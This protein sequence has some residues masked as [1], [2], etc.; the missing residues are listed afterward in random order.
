MG[1]PAAGASTATGIC[2]A[3]SSL[4]AAPGIVAGAACFSTGSDPGRA[5]VPASASPAPATLDVEGHAL[6]H[7]PA[8]AVA[9]GCRGIQEPNRRAGV[10]RPASPAISGSLSR[11]PGASTLRC[12]AGATGAG[13]ITTGS[14][15]SPVSALAGVTAAPSFSGV[16]PADAGSASGAAANTGIAGAGPLCWAATD[17]V[18]GAA[19][20]PAATG[21]PDDSGIW[22]SIS[23][24]TQSSSCG[25]RPCARARRGCRRLPARASTP[26]AA[27]GSRRVWRCAAITRLASA[28]SASAATPAASAAADAGT[29]AATAWTPGAVLTAW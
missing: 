7:S 16:S 23:S 24:L 19:S 12:R 13:A 5:V 27:A 10:S 8:R 18:A 3:S 28:C 29:R 14:S 17:G 22:R 6:S 20:C 1:G 2:G 4:I 9:G 15:S 25:A 21:I 11:V 26:A